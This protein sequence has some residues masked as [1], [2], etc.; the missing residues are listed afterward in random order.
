M[1]VDAQNIRDL[2]QRQLKKMRRKQKQFNRIVTSQNNQL[3]NSPQRSVTSQLPKYPSWNKIPSIEIDDVMTTQE[4]LG[5]YLKP[6]DI[7]L[8]FH[9][10]DCLVKLCDKFRLIR[11][12]IMDRNLQNNDSQ[13]LSFVQMLADN[14][15]QNHE[16][17]QF[18]LDSLITDTYKRGRYTWMNF[19]CEKLQNSL[20]ALIY[21]GKNCSEFFSKSH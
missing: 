5:F 1:K 21:Y 7:C 10:T 16:M 12:R 3:L 14:F 2:P 8:S 20:N 13:I 6:A 4:N 9:R 19:G 15:E 11:A 18:D 17:N